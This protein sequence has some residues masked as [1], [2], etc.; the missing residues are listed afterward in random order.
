MRDDDIVK[1]PYIAPLEHHH[2]IPF[3]ANAHRLCQIREH[4]RAGDDLSGEDAHNHR[5]YC[6]AVL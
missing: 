1:R 3:R 4:A 6:G 2:G 5:Q